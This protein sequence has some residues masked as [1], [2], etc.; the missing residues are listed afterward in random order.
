MQFSAPICVP[1]MFTA[2]VLLLFVAGVRGAL[3][4]GHVVLAPDDD[5]GGSRSAPAAGPRPDD[6]TGIFSCNEYEAE[7]LQII[8]LTDS[9]RSVLVLNAESR[10]ALWTHVDAAGFFD[11]GNAAGRPADLDPAKTPVG[12]GL[13]LHT[14]QTTFG[15]LD[16]ASSPQD[17][18]QAV[19][20]TSDPL[21]LSRLAPH[22][23]VVPFAP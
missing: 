9:R 6:G 18:W 23:S 13:R 7:G 20:R 5:D 8:P 21:R 2:V 1:C 3:A 14:K 12:A 22:I 16:V 10:W 11:A 15:R 19:L 4:Q 17:G